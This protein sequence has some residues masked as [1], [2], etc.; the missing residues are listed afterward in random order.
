[1]QADRRRAH[2]IDMVRGWLILIVVVYHTLYDLTAIFGVP[3]PFFWGRPF[4]AFRVS[5]VMAFLFISGMVSAYSQN[6][7]KRAGK[8][9]LYAALI[10]I[11][12]F[13]ALPDSPI[14]FGI[15][16]LYAACSLLYHLIGRFIKAP[17]AWIGATTCLCLFMV[18]YHVGEGYLYFGIANLDLPRCLYQTGWF[19]PL[20]FPGSDF[21]SADY[22]PVLPWIF[23]FL[24]G[25]FYAQDL[26][27]G[28]LPDYVYAPTRW[29][30]I[31]KIGRN[32]LAVYIIHQP[33]VLGV[34][35]LIFT[36]MPMR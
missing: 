24:C 18:F 9:V 30:I 26:K 22:Y 1:M 35:Y 34:L 17:A 19:M 15:I 6:S 11:V 29:P 31:E 13:F 10:S 14:Y 25:A 23:M 21:S 27:A 33:V 20:G 2:L 12:S 8:L 16:H 3:L 7:L 4:Q 28:E 32:T 36:V 5:C